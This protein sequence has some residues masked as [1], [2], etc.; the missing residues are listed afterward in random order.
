MIIALTVGLCWDWR[1]K[2]ICFQHMT[3]PT[4]LIKVHKDDKRKCPTIASPTSPTGGE[5]A[6]SNGGTRTSPRSP[7]TSH[8][9]GGVTPSSPNGITVSFSPTRGL[10]PTTELR[11]SPNGGPSLNSPTVGFS[12]NQHVPPRPTS[13]SV[14]PKRNTV[15]KPTAPPPPPPPASQENRKSPTEELDGGIKPEIPPKPVAIVPPRPETIQSKEPLLSDK[16]GETVQKP[17]IAVKPS[18]PFFSG[19]TR[20]GSGKTGTS[21]AEPPVAPYHTRPDVSQV[22]LLKNRFEKW[23]FRA[24]MTKKYYYLLT[25]VCSQRR[26]ISLRF[27]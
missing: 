20:A 2:K 15:T 9:N 4:S 18:F 22:S 1:H 12:H 16:A 24:L 13:A 7:T 3:S 6:L 26:K 14:L 23:F 21:T 8:L 5:A 19:W 10:S 17:D 27:F 11:T 25:W